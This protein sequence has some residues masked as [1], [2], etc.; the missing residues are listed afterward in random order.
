MKSLEVIQKIVK[1]LRILAK[2][3]YIL[4]I[5][6]AVAS[7]IGAASLFAIDERYTLSNINSRSPL[8]SVTNAGLG[9]T[10]G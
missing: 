10:N 9:E 2:I 3:A 4:C 1:V 5:I 8:I 7:A 6:G